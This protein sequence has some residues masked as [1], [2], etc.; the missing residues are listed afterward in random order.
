MYYLLIGLIIALIVDIK[1]PLN[2]LQFVMI[3]FI[4]TIFIWPAV[5]LY[6]FITYLRERKY[7]N[8]VL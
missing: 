5:L 3:R 4:S 2:S 7:R 1:L 8:V 6:L